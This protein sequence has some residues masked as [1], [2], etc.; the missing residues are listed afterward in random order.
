[1]FFFLLRMMNALSDAFSCPRDYEEKQYH[2]LMEDRENRQR[3]SE[4][5]ERG[6]QN[7]EE[8]RPSEERR[9]EARPQP[10]MRVE[11]NR[12]G[13]MANEMRALITRLFDEMKIYLKH[14]GGKRSL[15]RIY[16]LFDLICKVHT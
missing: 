7:E 8:D 1:M 11:F 16:F 13:P 4:E 6:K 10:H 12:H 9:R 3:K 15:T 5:D 2:L 14:E